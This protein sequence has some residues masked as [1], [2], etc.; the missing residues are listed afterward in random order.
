MTKQTNKTDGKTSQE[1]ERPTMTGDTVVDRR[2]FREANILKLFKELNNSNQIS[3]YDLVWCIT[4]KDL[5]YKCANE[6]AEGFKE[7]LNKEVQ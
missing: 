6:R 7:E 3:I 1:F 2:N 5:A 4:A